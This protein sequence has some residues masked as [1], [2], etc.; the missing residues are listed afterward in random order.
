MLISMPIKASY[1]ILHMIISTNY[2]GYG[3]V[4]LM[5]YRSMYLIQVY[6]L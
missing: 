1:I 2:Q 4:S 6:T 3:M 5:Y